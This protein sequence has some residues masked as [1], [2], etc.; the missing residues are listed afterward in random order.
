[1]FVFKAELLLENPTQAYA[2]ASVTFF[3]ISIYG[4]PLSKGLEPSFTP[5]VFNAPYSK[6][7]K[8][9][10]HQLIS[11]NWLRHRPPERVR[12]GFLTLRTPV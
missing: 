12:N 9:L 5:R 7:P 4:I 2:L 11:Y 6:S 10:F 1:M 8:L 3:L